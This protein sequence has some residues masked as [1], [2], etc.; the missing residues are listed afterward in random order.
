MNL[1]A[2]FLCCKLVGIAQKIG[3]QVKKCVI[4][5][6]VLQ[7]LPFLGTLCHLYVVWILSYNMITYQPQ[8][9]HIGY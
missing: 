7:Y 6:L 8:M 3:N 9:S 2:N 4:F 1:L 5:I